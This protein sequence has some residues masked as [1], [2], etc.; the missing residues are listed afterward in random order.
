MVRTESSRVVRPLAAVLSPA[1]PGCT[2]G[3]PLPLPS[4]GIR[5]IL[6]SMAW[7][8]F[9]KWITSRLPAQW[10]LSPPRDFELFPN[11]F[12]SANLRD[13]LFRRVVSHS[14]QPTWEYHFCFCL[15]KFPLHFCKNPDFSLI[16]FSLNWV[17][18]FCDSSSSASSVNG[19]T[20]GTPC[21]ILP[22]FPQHRDASRPTLGC[23]QVPKPAEKIVGNLK[24]KGF[25]THSMSCVKADRTWHL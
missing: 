23:P 8:C 25:M 4:R 20:L 16:V 18:T 17:N 12:S 3:L 2:A 10:G 15:K 9:F 21:F 11:L 14:F 7:L 6:S 24:E 13:V 1:Q 22:A 19:G 5:I